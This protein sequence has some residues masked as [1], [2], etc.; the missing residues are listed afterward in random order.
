M[1]IYLFF[2]FR[3]PSRQFVEDVAG[4]ILEARSGKRGQFLPSLIALGMEVITNGEKG[5]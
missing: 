2:E 5:D 3:I 4:K 1:D